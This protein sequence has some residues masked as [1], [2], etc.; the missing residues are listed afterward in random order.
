MLHAQTE[1]NTDTDTASTAATDTTDYT[2]AYI[3]DTAVNDTAVISTA[4]A[5]ATATA[6]DTDTAT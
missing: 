1:I 2:V 4:T 3:V 6:T 5:T